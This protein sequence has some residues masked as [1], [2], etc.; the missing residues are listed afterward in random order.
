MK[1]ILVT[2]GF[3]F[4]GSH[5]VR[6]LLERAEWKVVNLDALTYAGN[7]DNLASVK[8]DR[9][10]R[11]EKGDIADADLV[12]Q[13][14]QDNKPQAV[15]NFAAES[16]VD[17]SILDSSPFIKTNISGTQVLL[18]TARRYAVPRFIQIST[19][20]V[21][22]DID[23]NKACDEE[24]P[25]RPSSPYASSKASGDLLSLAYWRTFGMPVIIVRSSNN[26]GPH[27]FPEKLIPLMISKILDGAELPV[28]GDGLQRRDWLYVED[29]VR[30]IL[31][32]LEDGQVGSIYN[33]GTGKGRTNLEIV[34]T[35][36]QLLA[37]DVGIHLQDLLAR[38]R[39]MTDR[40]GHD[41]QY[42]LNCKRIHRELGWR[43]HVTFESGLERTVNWYL[44]HRGWVRQLT[45]GEYRDYHE[46]VY[47]RAWSQLK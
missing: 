36:C 16:H 24:S 21:Y 37:K 34:R 8:Q 38:I 17:R 18:E 27:Q 40:P 2:G 19:D 47:S 3:G 7:P 42:A 10:L 9:H 33:V 15:V 22:G 43:P 1:T 31:R 23:G 26:Y 29:N 5:F 44:D 14:F 6:L 20:E 32:V 30:A 46:A 35:I 12:N 41:R 4:I 45:S 28:Y 13:I 25:L 11:F 39:F